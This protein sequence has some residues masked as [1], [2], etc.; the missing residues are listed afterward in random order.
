[1]SYTELF[2]TTSTMSSKPRVLKH[3]IPKRPVFKRPVFKRPDPTTPP[4]CV[5]EDV[6]NQKNRVSGFAFKS[7]RQ[8]VPVMELYKVF[9]RIEKDSC[10]AKPSTTATS[11]AA[12]ATS[13]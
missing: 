1:M 12:P 5:K 2:G 3:S 10:K 4:R 9:K 13:T 6:A 11:A 7:L 8:N